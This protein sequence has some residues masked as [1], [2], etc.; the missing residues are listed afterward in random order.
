MAL[1]KPQPVRKELRYRKVRQI[2][3]DTFRDDL[4]D[5]LA[6]LVI[7]GNRSDMVNAYANTLSA[8]LDKHAPEKRRIIT[9]RHSQKG[10]TDEIKAER[11]K[12]RQLEKRSRR[13]NSEEDRHNYNVQRNMVNKMLEESESKLLSDTILQN[14]N[15]HRNLFNA[16]NSIMDHKPASPLP[17]HSSTQEQAKEFSKFF[18][19]KIEKIYSALQE[20]Q[21]CERRPEVSKYNTQF[22]EFNLL[23]ED[24]VRKLIMKAPAKSCELDPIPTW[25]LKLC[26]TELLPLLTHIINLSFHTAEM[27]DEYKLAILLPLL[28][29]IGLDLIMKNYR[30][31]SNLTFVSKLIERGAGS[32]L[33]KHMREDGL[34]EVFQSAYSEGKS[35][36]TALLR[37]K[38]DI[39]MA[40]DHQEVTVLIMLDL[41]AAFDTVNHTIL[42]DRLEKRCGVTGKALQWFMS[43]LSNRRQ[44]VKIEDSKSEESHLKCG[45]PQGSSMGPHLFNVYTLP[46]GDI[47]R[48]HGVSCHFYADDKQNYIS[49][50][51]KDLKPSL[52]KLRNCIIDVAKWLQE[53]FLQLNGDK[54]LFT[55]FGTPQQLNKLGPL[56]FEI[57]GNTIVLS[58]EVK[59]LGVIFDQNL[60]FKSHVSAV[61]RGAYYQLYNIQKIRPN[62]TE[63]AAHL[64]VN[65]FVTTRLDYANSLLYG[66][67]NCVLYNLQKVQNS[68]ARTLTGAKRVDHITPFLKGLHWLPIK[69]RVEF[70]IL[71]LMYKIKMGCAPR[72]LSDLVQVQEPSRSLRSTKEHKFIEPVTY[73]IPKVGSSSME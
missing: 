8:L 17:P 68:A 45:V 46:V 62:L 7:T 54:T 6:T 40:M 25:L 19:S 15:N 38:N 31:V 42:L 13:S 52:T 21:P 49:F 2:N 48:S 9:I 64:A 29:K 67:P 43:Y 37:V 36:E 41:S 58:S 53:N 4:K 12:K 32:Q 56:Q 3:V 66:L 1:A 39:L 14:S 57:G 44:M 27:P 18:T 59:N 61:S 34:F 55:V 51:P 70:K 69:R 5:A 11:R 26:L 22:K 24:E 30:P 50:K 10:M 65:A 35:T 47:I 23:T 16:L 63:E 73:L 28:K 72:Y 20:N 71:T 60:N 33:V